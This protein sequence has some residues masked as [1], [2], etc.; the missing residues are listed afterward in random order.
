MYKIFK[1]VYFLLKESMPDHKKLWND[2]CDLYYLDLLEKSLNVIPTPPKPFFEMEDAELNSW[3]SKVD[4]DKLNVGRE[5]KFRV[6]VPKKQTLCKNSQTKKTDVINLPLS[7]EDNSTLNGTAAI[8]EEFGREF[9]IPCPKTYDIPFNS[10]AKNFDLVAARTQY[11][12]MRSVEMHRNKMAEIEKQIS[13]ME[14]GLDG[15]T[16]SNPTMDSESDS[17]EDEEIREPVKTP[18]QQKDEKFAEFCN[19]I[20]KQV[21]EASHSNDDFALDNLVYQLSNDVK[22]INSTTDRYERTI[23][24]YAVEGKN[25]VMVKVL[26]AVGVNPNCKEG[27][28]ATPMS[29][30]VMNADTNMCKLLLDNFAEYSGPLFGAFPNPMKMAASM[31]LTEIVD[32][33]NKHFEVTSEHPLLSVLQSDNPYS[34]PEQSTLD[35]AKSPNNDGS[36]QTESAFSYTRSVY[37]GFPTGI[38]GDVGTCKVN[39]GVKNRNGTAYGWSTEI[40][41]DMH[42]KGHLCEAAFKAHGK[43]GFHKVVHDVMKRPKLTEEAFKKRKFQQQNLQHIQ[44]AV[45]DGSCAYGMAAIYEFKASNEFPSDDDLKTALR[46]DGNHNKIL[47]EKFKLWLEQSR[48]CDESHKYHQELFCLFGPLLDLFIT[49]GREG[50]GFLRETAWVLLLPI[51]AQLDFRNYWTEAFVH[52]V[53][54]TSLWPLAFRRMVKQNSSVNISGKRGHNLD[55]D[56]YVETYVV[57]PLKTYSTG[58]HNSTFLL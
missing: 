27:C 4:F 35:P 7:L 55:M 1:T 38:V 56:E 15:S 19:R 46:K 41:G 22:A 50:D 16:S 58:M 36:P 49:A 9:S 57:R 8:Y 2:W 33:F 47:L 23:F 10:S 43:G 3:L 45:R 18:N 39:R 42:A 52:V 24:H 51:F 54:F 37:A 31:E 29:L 26:L 11:E 21:K 28:G 5:E 44:E 17:G 6:S 25:Y 34:T 14:K 48:E 40:P 20:S 30:A 32:L 53:N 12:F 13:S